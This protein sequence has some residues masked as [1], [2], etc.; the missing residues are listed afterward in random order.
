MGWSWSVIYFELIHQWG[1]KMELPL[2]K[3]QA[4]LLLVSYK[5]PHKDCDREGNNFLFKLLK[6]LKQGSS[7][8]K[9]T[10]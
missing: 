10:P 8:N 1:F 6:L 9:L 5:L 7:R 4:D 3:K 2:S